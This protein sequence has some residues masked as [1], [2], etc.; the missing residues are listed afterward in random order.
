MTKTTRT[1][2][3]LFFVIA[4]SW[5]AAPSTFAQCVLGPGPGTV[6]ITYSWPPLSSVGFI[7]NSVP[8]GPMSTAI[9]NWNSQLAAA[10]CGPTLFQG[11]IAFQPTV[12]MTY[13]PIPPPSNCPSCVTRGVTNLNSASFQNRRIFAVTMTI[14]SQVTDTTALTE[15]IAHE[16]GHT[17]AL[18]DCSYPVC[19]VYSSVMETNA[20]TTVNGSI[21]LPGPNNCDMSAVYSIAVDYQCSTC[22]VQ[23][24]NTCV[25]N[26]I[27]CICKSGSPIIIDISGKGFDLTNA[28]NGVKF[29]IFGTGTPV[30]MGWTSP[31][32]NNAFLALPGA[33]GFVHNGK[34][35]FGDFTPQPKSSTPN[36]FAALAV[37]DD[38]KNGGNGDG[39]IDAKDAVFASLRLWIDAN[40]DGISQP[41]E[42]HT[43]PSLG[44]N[45]I[46]L[47]YHLSKRVDEYGNLLR[48]K[49][50][51][52]PDDPDEAHVGRTAYDVF[53]M[54]VDPISANAPTCTRPPTLAAAMNGNFK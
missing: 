47:D 24:S 38:P 34:Q 21:G 19:P 22:D 13:G 5:L 28:A 30:Q 3:I 44:V 35:L 9:A 43:L 6:T 39:V 17:F 4:S 49:S 41:E 25:L 50:K 14:N 7:F 12:A 33:D 26:P 29:D 8:S 31:G 20:P 1:L 32:A 2:T 45:S 54:L 10:P 18:T 27:T 16:I 53:F 23:P 37:Y 11:S 46:S 40:H 48:Y 51:V 52:N 36:G 15:V 42:L